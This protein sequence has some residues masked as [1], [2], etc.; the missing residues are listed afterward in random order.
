MI[1]RLLKDYTQPLGLRGLIPIFIK[2]QHNHKG[3]D[4]NNRRNTHNIRG[5]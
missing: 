5:R 1:C 2:D 4:L 3:L